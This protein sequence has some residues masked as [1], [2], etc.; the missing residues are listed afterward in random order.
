MFVVVRTRFLQHR[1]EDLMQML[2]AGVIEGNKKV[3]K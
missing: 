1:L 3:L 2:A